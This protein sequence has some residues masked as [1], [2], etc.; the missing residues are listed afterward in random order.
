VFG[1][2]AY[3]IYST[4]VREPEAAGPLA[5]LTAYASILVWITVAMGGRWIAFA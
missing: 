3:Q 1:I 5:Q 2:G 4:K